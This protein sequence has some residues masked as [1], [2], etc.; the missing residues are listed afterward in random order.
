MT[1]GTDPWDDFGLPFLPPLSHLGIDLVSELGF[2]LA[3]ITSKE[4]EKTLC[5]TVDDVDLV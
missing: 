4:S 1:N 5:P 2:D 3:S